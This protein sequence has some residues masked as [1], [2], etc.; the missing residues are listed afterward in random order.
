MKLKLF[1]GLAGFT[2]AISTRFDDNSCA[3]KTTSGF[4]DATQKRVK[5]LKACKEHCWP[6]DLV[7]GDGRT[8]YKFFGLK[9][10][11]PSVTGDGNYLSCLC[12][13]ARPAVA[14]L[15]DKKSCTTCFKIDTLW[16][17]V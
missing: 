7:E 3:I 2:Q 5:S 1:I 9:A 14:V 15:E 17:S 10:S 16:N 12:G 11:C 6:S 13:H 8:K 4:N